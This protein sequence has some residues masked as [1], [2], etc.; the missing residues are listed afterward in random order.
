MRT[1]KHLP[2]AAASVAAG[3]LLAPAAAHAQAPTTGGSV[4][5]AKVKPVSIGPPKGMIPHYEGPAYDASA[6]PRRIVIA[7]G[8]SLK[9]KVTGAPGDLTYVAKGDALPSYAAPSDALVAGAKDAA[10]ADLWFNGQP[11]IG[12]NPAIGGPTGTKITGKKTVTSGVLGLGPAKTWKVKFP[13]AGTYKLVSAFHSGVKLTVVVKRHGA[14]TPSIGQ[15]RKAIAKQL[16]ATTKLA[17]KLTQA[18]GPANAIQAGSDAKGVATIGFYPAAKTIKAGES[19]TFEMSKRSIEFHNVAFGP[20]DYIGEQIKTFFGEDGTL[21]PF[22]TYRSE[23]PGAPITFDGANH[24]NG[25]VNTGIIDANPA[26]AF[27][28]KETVTFTKAGTYTYYCVVHGPDM[29]GT[30]TVQ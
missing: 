21:N 22:V 26:S 30:I 16:R 7:A 29:K 11:K 23:Q 10:G 8:D 4:D 12:L 15:D 2:W 3:V 28:S 1:P 17:R 6:Y 27:P 19:V 18:K 5:H 13:K 25:F 20:E 14:P 24:G 9:V